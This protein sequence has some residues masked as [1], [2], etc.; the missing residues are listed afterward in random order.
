MHRRDRVA[1]VLLRLG[2]GL[3]AFEGGVQML[4][5]SWGSSDL[6]MLISSGLEQA[7]LA[8]EL[9]IGLQTLQSNSAWLSQ[10]VVLLHLIGGLLLTVGLL[11]R[12]SALA[13]SLLYGSY[14]L[15]WPSATPMLLALSFGAVAL[16][17]A[18][19][20]FTLQRYVRV[21]QANHQPTETT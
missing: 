7:M 1:L 2:L 3:A 12:S 5:S 13:L 17:D 10:L 16:S 14:C 9:G 20:R 11:T 15:I 6:R 21:T 4:R 8:P 19:E 18:G